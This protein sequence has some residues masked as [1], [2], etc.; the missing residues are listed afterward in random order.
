MYKW[1]II[2]MSSLAFT[3]VN[4][5][6]GTDSNPPPPEE[7]SVDEGQ[8]GCEVGQPPS[9]AACPCKGKGK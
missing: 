3:A 1:L 4:A 5:Q 9:L 8:G 2:A 6:E 7:I